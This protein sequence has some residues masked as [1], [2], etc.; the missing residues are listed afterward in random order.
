MP[1]WL[2]DRGAGR[3][4]IYGLAPDPLAAADP[5]GTPAP[6]RHPKV[7]LH[8]SSEVVD[9]DLGAAPVSNADLDGLRHAYEAVA[10]ALAGEHVAAATCLYTMSPDG[11]F[12][13]GR[14][15]G[16]R[17]TYFA[18]G[19][20]GHGFKLVPALGDALVN[21]AIRGRT[22]LPVEFLAPARLLD[23]R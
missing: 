23:L 15:R 1:C 11:H 7:A 3:P 8:G 5:D 4:A 20:S 9:P 21:L 14:R 6:G 2:Y 19:L 22:D 13:V 16:T 18:A 17:R 10:P 12:L